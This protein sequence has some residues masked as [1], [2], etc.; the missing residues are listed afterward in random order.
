[1]TRLL[2]QSRNR[3]LEGVLSLTLGEDYEVRV[4]ADQEKVKQA[5]ASSATD[6]LILD[7]VDGSYTLKGALNHIS[8]L[9]AYKTPILAMTDDD[10]RSTAMALVEHGV[11]DY[12]R[13]PPHL[14]ELK[15]V[16]RRAYEQA[17]LRRSL[18]V[19]S[20]KLQD[21]TSCDQLIGSTAQMQVVYDLVRKVSNLNAFVMIQGESG[22]GK[23]LVAR[24]IHNL[25]KR[26]E[27]PFVTVSCGAIPETLIEAELFGSEKGAYTGSFRPREGYLEQAAEGTILLDEIGELGLTTQVKLLRVLQEKEFCRLGSSKP[28]PLRARVLFATHRNLAEMV[29]EGSFRQDLY[30][31]VNVL[32]IE[33]P[34]LRERPEDISC[35]ASHFADVYAKTY[36]KPVQRIHPR[37]MEVL[38]G[39]DWPGNVRELENVIQRAVILSEGGFIGASDLPEALQSTIPQEEAGDVSDSSLEEQLKE[40]KVKLVN[41]AL[42]ASNGN[43]TEAARRLSITRAYL[44]RLLRLGETDSR[45]A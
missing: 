26:A 25:S 23:G 17:Q 34:A 27:S 22:T 3:A 9:Q 15:L 38:L 40:Y 31:R 28:I 7:L 29:K 21:L 16:I 2:I 13:T 4:E 10:R 35:L 33:L 32:T 44:Y 36:Q 1:M 24:A 12:F 43:K 14:L 41:E 8:E 39:Y 37:A 18:E 5:L 20:K 11:Y 30:F 19:V 45:V 6:V 42:Q